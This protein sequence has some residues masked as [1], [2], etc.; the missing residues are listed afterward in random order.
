MSRK[1]QLY[2]HNQ[3]LSPSVMADSGSYNVS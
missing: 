3:H 2:T 1:N